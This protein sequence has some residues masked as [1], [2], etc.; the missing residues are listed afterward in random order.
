VLQYILH[1]TAPAVIIFWARHIVIQSP[2]ASNVSS[3]QLK[4]EVTCR[5]QCFYSQCTSIDLLQFDVAVE[6]KETLSDFSLTQWHTS[7]LIE[8]NNALIIEA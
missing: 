5:S 2:S 3:G 7:L 8:P 1:A 6:G 4:E